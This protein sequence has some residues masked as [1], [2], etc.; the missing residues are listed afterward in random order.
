MWQTTAMIYKYIISRKLKSYLQVILPYSSDVL[1]MRRAMLYFSHTFSIYISEARQKYPAS[2]LPPL[3]PPDDLQ[4][5]F[6]PTLLNLNF[7][8]FAQAELQKL[9]H[10]CSDFILEQPR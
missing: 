10:P 3:P 4:L 8:Q 7:W 6:F 1:R 2:L 9:F 5:F